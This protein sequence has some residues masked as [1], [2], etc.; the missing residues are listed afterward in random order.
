MRQKQSIDIPS[1]KQTAPELYVAADQH[2]DALHPAV[3]LHS[4]AQWLMNSTGFLR[5]GPTW[6]LKMLGAG[7]LLAGQ[8]LPK[9]Q[10]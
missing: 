2:F 6:H 4:C 10:D 3:L 9:N 8:F 7:L 5:Q 1:E